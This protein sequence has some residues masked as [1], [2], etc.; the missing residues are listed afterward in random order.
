MPWQQYRFAMFKDEMM[1]KYFHL[2]GNYMIKYVMK[3]P[4]S[5]TESVIIQSWIDTTGK[6]FFHVKF[7]RHFYGFIVLMIVMSFVNL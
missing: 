5:I 1:A 2:I 6:D 4:K 3:L 7:K